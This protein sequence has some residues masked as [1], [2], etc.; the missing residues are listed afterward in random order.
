MV[1]CELMGGLGNQLFQIAATTALALRNNDEACFDID[2]HR[3]SLQGKDAIDYK[4]IIYTK[5]NN[6]KLETN[7]EFHQNGH[8]FEEIPYKQNL[9]I[10][11]FFQSEKYFNDYSDVIK[12]L[13]NPIDAVKEY[14]NNKYGDIINKK[15]CSIHV[16][17]GDYMGLATHHPPCQPQYYYGAIKQFDGDTLFLVFSDDIEWCKSIFKG[18]NFIFISN[19]EDYIDLHLISLCKNNIIANSSFSWW[20]AYL[21]KNENKKVIAPSKWFGRALSHL[22][23]DDI[24]TNKMIKL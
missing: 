13:L 11:G 20:G 2:G 1:T 12:D 10:V 15:T 8:H 6:K 9:K 21:N 16:R 23:T 19:E 14:V 18:D 24:Y 3:I 22:N 4:N 7:V 17:H 5:L